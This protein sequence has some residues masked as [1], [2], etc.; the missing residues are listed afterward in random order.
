MGKEAGKN[1]YEP[2]VTVTVTNS[3]QGAAAAAGSHPAS[4][5]GRAQR[6]V[7]WVFLR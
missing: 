5:S 1:E 4:L 2:M 7:G 6:V 3:V